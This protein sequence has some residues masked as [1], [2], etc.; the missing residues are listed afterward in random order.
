M[1][2]VRALD[3]VECSRL[4]PLRWRGDGKRRAVEAAVST[5]LPSRRGISTSSKKALA[6]DVAAGLREARLR[7]LLGPEEKVVHVE[8]RAAVNILQQLARRRLAAGA[9]PP[10]ATSTRLLSAAR[11]RSM[12][13]QRQRAGRSRATGREPRGRNSAE[14]S[15]EWCSGGSRPCATS[16]Q[17]PRRLLRNGLARRVD[18]HWQGS[19]IARAFSRPHSSRAAQR[20]RRSRAN[21]SALK[22]SC[23]NAEVHTAVVAAEQLDELRRPRSPLRAASARM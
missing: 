10:V 6:V 5:G 8:D 21:V 3:N 18:S 9:L 17:L 7:A 4:N 19:G 11:G 2:G 1:H 16:Q 13:K 23:E 20:G 14:I 15:P 12:R 22:P